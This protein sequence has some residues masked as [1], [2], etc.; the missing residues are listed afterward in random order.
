AYPDGVVTDLRPRQTDLNKRLSQIADNADRIANPPL[1]VPSTL[2]DDFVW[3]GLPGERVDYQDTGSP[4][5]MPSFMDVPN[6]PA[7]VEND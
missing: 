1:L 4:N 7:Y 6:L 5:A 3:S 2:G